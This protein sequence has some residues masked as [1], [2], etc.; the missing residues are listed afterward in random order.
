MNWVY[1]EYYRHLDSLYYVIRYRENGDMSI[2]PYGFKTK[3]GAISY[4]AAHGLCA[5]ERS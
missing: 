3:E 4:I 2:T 5:K 1:M